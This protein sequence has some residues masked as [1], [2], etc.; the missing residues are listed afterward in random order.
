MKL[1]GTFEYAPDGTL[2]RA[3]VSK[4]CLELGPSTNAPDLGVVVQTEP[5][6]QR[7]AFRGRLQL[8]KSRISARQANGPSSVEQAVTRYPSYLRDEMERKELSRF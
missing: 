7:E 6:S 3:N 4:S 5:A 1:S 8:H 2:V